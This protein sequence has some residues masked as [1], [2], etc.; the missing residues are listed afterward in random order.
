MKIRG[1]A[2]TNKQTAQSETST[3]K[4]GDWP[5]LTFAKEV[6]S[7]FIS[8]LIAA[9]IIEESLKYEVLI[10]EG[11]E[12]QNV[13]EFLSSRQHFSELLVCKI[14]HYTLLGKISVLIHTIYV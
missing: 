1:S 10:H 8:R 6:L 3:L 2:V 7:P 14:V 4:A 5:E 9:Y 11:L 13:L 12:G